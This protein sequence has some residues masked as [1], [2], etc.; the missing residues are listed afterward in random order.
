MEA[1]SAHPNHVAP[2]FKLRFPNPAALIEYVSPRFDAHADA[3]HFIADR[4]MARMGAGVVVGGS[5]ATGFPANVLSGRG[6]RDLDVS[7]PLQG[8][9]LLALE[10][11][12]RHKALDRI[13]AGFL[14]TDL[15][16][17]VTLE[18]HRVKEGDAGALYK[19]IAK[20]GSQRIGDTYL[21]VDCDPHLAAPVVYSNEPFCRT[22]IPGLTPGLRT[23]QNPA[24]VFAGKVE[25]INLMAAAGDKPRYA[26]HLCD[27]RQMLALG[28]VDKRMAAASI[29]AISR[30]TGRP[31][32]EM[33]PLRYIG[34]ASDRYR[35][36][37][38]KVSPG[39]SLPMHILSRDF[40]EVSAALRP[41][42]AA[43]DRG[44]T[45]PTVSSADIAAMLAHEPTPPGLSP[46]DSSRRGTF[47]VAP[48]EEIAGAIQ[49]IPSP[50]SHQAPTGDRGRVT[51][52]SK[53]SES[54]SRS[55]RSPSR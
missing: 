29:A 17:Y 20:V 27:L 4:I 14:T 38:K 55:S 34:S 21:D 48:P 25:A 3:S 16:D 54:P 39:E 47:P 32:S 7:L 2:W 37:R 33:F 24:D 50:D 43:A 9:E 31:L 35:S 52:A 6:V 44:D 28:L 42:I 18:P 8:P 26:R 40:H 49:Q 23:L 5:R 36:Q 13:V 53:A 46:A 22:E 41:I 45:R 10:D 12:G 19:V 11:E 1:P 30:K 15:G 51:R